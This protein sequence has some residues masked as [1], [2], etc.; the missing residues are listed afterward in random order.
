MTADTPA[1]DELTARVE[2][3]GIRLAILKYQ[4]SKAKKAYDQAS[5]R[6]YADFA[7]ARNK[8]IP[9]VKPRLPDGSEPGLFSLLSGGQDVDTDEDLLLSIIAAGAPADL[10][11]YVVPAAWTDDR[12]IKLLTGHFPEFVAVRIKPA[13]RAELQTQIEEKNGHIADPLTGEPEKV[14]TVTPRDANGQF[15]FR[16]GTRFEQQITA[17]LEAGLI[18]A[19]GAITQATAESEQ[20]A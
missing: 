19:D 17:A 20:Q 15:Q 3:H 7:A 12:V 2:A 10:E 8:G 11:D 6:A 9:Q 14:A 5:Q 1:R 13:V 18:T 16:P 4:A